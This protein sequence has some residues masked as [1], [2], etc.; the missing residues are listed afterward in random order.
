MNKRLY[1]SVNERKFTGVCGGMA[2]YLGIDPAIV[3]IAWFVITWFHGFGIVLYL[4]MALILSDDPEEIVAGQKTA[5]ERPDPGQDKT[6]EF[7][8]AKEVEIV[9]EEDR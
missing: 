5:E 4:A 8:D 9:D 2:K 6:V 7:V 3:R 1:K